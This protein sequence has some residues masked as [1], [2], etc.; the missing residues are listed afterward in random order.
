MKRISLSLLFCLLVPG[1]S[2]VLAQD[3]NEAEMKKVAG[4]YERLVRN[5]AG[6]TFRIIKEELPE[7]QSIVTTYDDVG[8]VVVAHTA[9][10]K[11][12]KRG[13][14]GVFSFFNLVVTAGPQKGH[15]ELGTNSYIYRVDDD[16]FTEAWGLLEGDTNPPQMLI[17]RR[18]KEAKP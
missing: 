8:N 15:T 3:N 9:T 5:A 7:G 6:T 14:V 11:V 16:S 12:E 18:I 4:R 1:P 2:F 10:F 13:P 17:W